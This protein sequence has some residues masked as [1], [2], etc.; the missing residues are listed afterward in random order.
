[1]FDR[2]WCFADP[3]PRN[4]PLNMAL[5]ELMLDFSATEQTPVLRMY[6]WSEPFVSIGYFDRI[7]VIEAQ[8]PGRLLVR[9]WTGGGAVDHRA[10]FTFSLAVPAGNALARL[11]GEQRYRE[12]HAWVAS[13]LER[14]GIPTQSAGHMIAVARAAA[15]APCF[16]WAVGGDLLSG[17]KKIVG[18][19]QRRTRLGVL[20]QG[21]IQTPASAAD[22]SALGGA[23]AGAF[24]REQMP[25]R[26]EAELLER[27]S[28]LAESK[29]A[30]SAWLRAH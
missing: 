2:L 1:M 19:A 17:E 27:A 8:F 4:G 24:A 15:P 9:R 14:C 7:S 3:V 30:A 21:S 6:R 18:G 13:A 11:P 23:V 20:H 5:D 22:R 16:E 28:A 10:D 29:Y 26:P 25:L 12:I